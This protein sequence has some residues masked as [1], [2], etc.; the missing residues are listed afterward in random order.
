MQGTV[1]V[2]GIGS[3]AEV[4]VSGEGGTAFVDKARYEV[5]PD[6]NALVKIYGT[7][8]NP[9]GGT[10]VFMSVTFPDGHIE[11][12]EV[13]KTT[14]GYYETFLNIDSENQYILEWVQNGRIWKVYFDTEEELISYKKALNQ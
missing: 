9:R 14:S 13:N 2:T 8:V 6:E 5:I 10:T 1:I 12:L 11:E 3:D 7:L 4:Y